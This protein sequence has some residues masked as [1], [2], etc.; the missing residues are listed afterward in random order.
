VLESD[1]F[2]QPGKI[3]DW[4][5]FLKSVF[6]KRADWDMIHVGKGAESEL[7]GKPFCDSPLPYRETPPSWLPQ[8]Y[9]EDLTTP[10]ERFR[11]FRKFHT[12]CTDSLLWTYS[13]VLKM[14]QYMEQFPVYDTPLDYYL[15][16][17]LETE[18][19]FKHYWSADTF[20]IQGSN[21]GTDSS[22]I[23]LDTE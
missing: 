21:Y 1:V 19:M 2:E 10:E 20:F 7:L 3:P 5:D 11:L 9:I 4:N 22:A 13:G 15:I 23:Q 18:F 12:R 14:K 16:Q 8:H 6:E 17:F